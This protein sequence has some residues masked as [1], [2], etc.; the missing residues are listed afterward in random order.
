[1][2]LKVYRKSQE[3]RFALAKNELSAITVKFIRILSISIG[4][5][6][7]ITAASADLMGLSSGRGATGAC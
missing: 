2:L 6:I 4:I 5:L 3:K 7:L 1:M